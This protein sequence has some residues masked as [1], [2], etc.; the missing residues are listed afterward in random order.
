MLGRE[1]RTADQSVGLLMHE[2]RRK[3][4][5]DRVLGDGLHCKLSCNLRI[6][7]AVAV[8]FVLAMHDFNKTASGGG[9]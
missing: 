9:W 6:A 8:R 1:G 4:A 5:L 2:Y 3:V 7:T